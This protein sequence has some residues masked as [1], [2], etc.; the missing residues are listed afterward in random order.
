[1]DGSNSRSCTHR[2]ARATYDTPRGR[3]RWGSATSHWP[4]RTSMQVLQSSVPAALTASQLPCPVGSRS[5]VRRRRLRP[6]R[7]RQVP[8][9]IGGASSLGW[10]WFQRGHGTAAN[11]SR[12]EP[13]PAPD[14]PTSTRKLLGGNSVLPRTRRFPHY[15]GAVPGRIGPSGKARSVAPGVR[16]PLLVRIL[17]IPREAADLYGAVLSGFSWKNVPSLQPVPRFLP[18]FLPPARMIKANRSQVW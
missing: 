5:T 7:N 16:V 2:R 8:P 15:R 1:M 10:G 12:P 13:P 9:F 17:R 3:M 11:E 4:S 18:R 6:E 14:C